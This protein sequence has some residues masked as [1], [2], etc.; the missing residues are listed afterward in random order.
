[1][2]FQELQTLAA[3]HDCKVHWGVI[4]NGNNP[5]YGQPALFVNCRSNGRATHFIGDAEEQQGFAASWIEKER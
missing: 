5:F 2:T 4:R 1:M 3:K